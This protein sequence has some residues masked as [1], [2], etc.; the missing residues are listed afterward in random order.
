M[1]AHPS[2]LSATQLVAHGLT[3]AQCLYDPE[4]HTGPAA[5]IEAP[6]DKA[7]R[8]D[9]AREICQSCPVAAACRARAAKG[10]PEPGVWASLTISTRTARPGL[11]D[12]LG[13]DELGE[14][15]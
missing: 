7:A 10:R 14:V 8:E 12:G 2:K 4:L 9:V 15:A 1:S 11:S 5:T 13:G 3:E 6:E